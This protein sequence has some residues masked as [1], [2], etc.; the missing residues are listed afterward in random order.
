MAGIPLI[1]L[2]RSIVVIAATVVPAA[3]VIIAVS[4]PAAIVVIIAIAAPAAVVI[5]V[6]TAKTIAPTLCATLQ[7]T[8][9]NL[10]EKRLSRVTSFVGD[11]D[12]RHCDAAQQHEART[13]F[14]RF[15]QNSTVVMQ[16]F[17]AASRLR[18]SGRFIPSARKDFLVSLSEPGCRQCPFR[19]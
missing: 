17:V 15:T 1:R 6:A 2:G 4:A 5:I 7:V 9:H 19:S 10:P 11:G 13:G 8:I 16:P 14:R 3:I 18:L 12:G